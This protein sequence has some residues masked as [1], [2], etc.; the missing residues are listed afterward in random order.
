MSRCYYVYILASRSR[1][2]YTG[3]TN[4]LRRRII[5]HREGRVPGFTTRYRILRLVHYEVFRDIRLAIAREKEIKGWGHKKKLRLIQRTNRTWQDLAADWHA[6]M[7]R[8]RAALQAAEEAQH[9]GRTE[10]S[11]IAENGERPE[12]QGEETADPSP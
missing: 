5:E 9:Q 11:S 8:Q 2:L 6:G 7:E 10:S 3:V 12:A 4:S 1:N